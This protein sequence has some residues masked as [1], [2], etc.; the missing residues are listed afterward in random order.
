MQREGFSCWYY[1]HDALPGISYVTQTARAIKQSDAVVLLISPESIVSPDVGREIQEVHQLGRPFLPMLFG[2]TLREFRQRQPDWQPTIG[3]AAIIDLT[4]LN[5][6]SAVSRLIKTLRLWAIP[7]RPRHVHQS[8]ALTDGVAPS[9]S[10]TGD[11]STVPRKIWA[12]DANQIEIYDLN[13]VVFRN[14]AVEDFLER[15][16]KFFL[17]ASK[18]FGKTLL[19]TFKRTLLMQMFQRQGS[20]NSQAGVIFVPQGRP[21]LDFMSDVRSLSKHHELLVSDLL[22]TKRMWNL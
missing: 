12:S 20:A 3:P 22:N 7:P 9:A 18:G 8:P 15:R 21:Y 2:L 11:L 17:S 6:A 10:A 1:E 5:L 19:L 14:A 4:E 13:S 16:N